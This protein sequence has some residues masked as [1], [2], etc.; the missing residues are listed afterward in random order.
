LAGKRILVV[1][2]DADARLMF[3]LIFE[4]GGYQVSEARNGVGALILIKDSL[5][6]LVVTDMVM[7]MMGG[8]ELIAR[9]RADP[10]T[11]QLLI[12]AVTG[13]PGAK[14]QTSGA[15]AVLEKPFDRLDLLA[16]VASLI[17]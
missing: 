17:E 15:D 10:R 3:Q 12:L 9:L 16:T 6:D 13:Q 14:E 2:D 11:A 8:E 5:P 1:D 4:S 7:P